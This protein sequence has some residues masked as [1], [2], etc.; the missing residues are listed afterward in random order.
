MKDT[1]AKTSI[2]VDDLTGEEE[3]HGAEAV[4]RIVLSLIRSWAPVEGI[5]IVA[6]QFLKAVLER[7]GDSTQKPKRKAR[8]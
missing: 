3:W 7:R 2:I 6:E 8:R 4:W 5:T 1:A